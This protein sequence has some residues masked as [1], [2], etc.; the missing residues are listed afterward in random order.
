[1]LERIVARPGEIIVRAPLAAVVVRRPELRGLVDV[2]EASDALAVVPIA[3]AGEIE[4][5]LFV[6][7][8]RRRAPVTLEELAA[9][10]RL[11]ARLSSLLALGAAEVRAERRAQAAQQAAE[12]L[13]ERVEALTDELTRL[14]VDARIL[15][16]GRAADRLAAPAIAYSPAMRALLARISEVAPLDAPVQLVSEGGNPV[17][18]IGHLIHAASGAREG[19][20]VIAD[21]TAVRPERAAAAL[22]GDESEGQQHP[23]WLRLAHGGTLLLVDVPALAPDTQRALAEAI[24]T[25]T[26]R[27]EG[28][29]SA[30]DVQVRLVATSRMDALAL[31]RVGALDE[32]L[33]RRLAP[34]TLE[35]PPLRERREDL[36]SLVLLALDRSARVLGKPVPGIDDGAMARLVGYAWP[37]NV[38]ELWSV[39]DRAVAQAAGPRVT[40]EDLPPLQDPTA[41]AASET[42]GD[43][44]AGTWADIERRA[45]EAALARSAGNKSEAARTL[46]LARTTFL[47]KLRRAGLETADRPSE[48]PGRV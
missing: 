19:P 16:A 24:A 7:R 25:R 5:A 21:C 34:L 38:R 1:V 32:E 9:L 42:A 15:K 6:P 43:P 27:P 35:L 2:L 40:L 22:F 45:L 37:G 18:A 14:R 39:I 48:A 26:A 36:P 13:E 44:F 29:A 47:D 17:D 28:G 8:G 23:G 30:Y 33:S 31:A 3:I 12:K 10:E 41:A 4:G 20:Y 46:G 11:G